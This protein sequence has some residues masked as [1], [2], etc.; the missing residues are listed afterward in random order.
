MLGCQQ[1]RGYSLRVLGLV[2]TK[3]NERGNRQEGAGGGGQG[4]R[5]SGQAGQFRQR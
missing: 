1:I 3:E 5:V 4:I 2:N